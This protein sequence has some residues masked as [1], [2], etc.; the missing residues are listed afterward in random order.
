MSDSAENK[1]RSAR[2]S[3][4]KLDRLLIEK[5]LEP[6]RPGNKTGC[7]I[8]VKAAKRRPGKKEG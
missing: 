5:G 6:T 7:V 2:E 1:K 8:I 3:I 4:A